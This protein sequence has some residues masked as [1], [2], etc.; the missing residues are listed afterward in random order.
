MDIISYTDNKDKSIIN[1]IK[2]NRLKKR[3]ISILKKDIY[4]LKN[5]LNSPIDGYKIYELAFY[6]YN[7]FYNHIYRNIVV[8]NYDRP[9]MFRLSIGKLLDDNIDIKAIIRVYD[10]ND[11]F[12][13]TIIDNSYSNKKIY[14]L[15]LKSLYHNNRSINKALIAINDKIVD[16]I[17]SYLLDM[18]EE[19]K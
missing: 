13:I 3:Y 12:N 19:D 7:N 6:I 17:I 4:K 1:R 16:T 15:E 2:N 11:R 5:N 10:N 9:D 8:Y 18:I 14:E